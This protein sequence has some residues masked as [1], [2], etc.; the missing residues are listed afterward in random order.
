MK[1]PS[2]NHDQLEILSKEGRLEGVNADSS[3][4]ILQ[5]EESSELKVYDIEYLIGE[6]AG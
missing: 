6:G 5:K 4:V 1:E 3:H 2:I